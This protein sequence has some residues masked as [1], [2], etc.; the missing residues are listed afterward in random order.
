MKD[1][2]LCIGDKVILVKPLNDKLDIVGFQ[3]EIGGITE[4]FYVIRQCNTG[5][6]ITSV[7]TNC[8]DEYFV[9]ADQNYQ[10]TEWGA[11]FGE[12][13]ECAI[14]LFRTNR[15]KVQVKIG[16]DIGEASC[17]IKNGDTFNLATGVRLAYLRCKIKQMKSIINPLQ[18]S[19]YDYE[20]Q[21]KNRINKSFVFPN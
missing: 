18:D 14:A 1:K 6:A 21:I 9:K 13:R 5:L 12:D 3:Y 11:L 7:N 17:N 19:V 8:F 20:N 10:W 2:S 15:K 16:D 4:D